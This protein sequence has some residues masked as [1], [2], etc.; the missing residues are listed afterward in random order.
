MASQ[1]IEIATQ[2]ANAYPEATSEQISTSIIESIESGLML[3]DIFEA[4][5]LPHRQRRLLEKLRLRRYPKKRAIHAQQKIELIDFFE[6]IKSLYTSADGYSTSTPFAGRDGAGV[7]S[8]GR[9]QLTD[10]TSVRAW[11]VEVTKPHVGLQLLESM[12]SHM[13]DDQLLEL[14]KEPFPHYTGEFIVSLPKILED[15]DQKVN[16]KQTLVF[17]DVAKFNRALEFLEDEPDLNEILTIL[18][19]DVELRK[20]IFYVDCV[21]ELYGAEDLLPKK[22]HTPRPRRH[23]VRDLIYERVRAIVVHEY[24]R[25]HRLAGQDFING[26]ITYGEYAQR[27]K[28]Y[29]LDADGLY[30]GYS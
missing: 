8:A 24:R 27:T 10:K 13:T 28:R 22:L 30:P 6:R 18:N 14:L 15:L 2:L 11:G 21:E 12:E 20:E 1:L 26:K 29:A 25:L 3:Q 9:F 4:V 7:T 16:N 5:R 17:D 19:K 23:N